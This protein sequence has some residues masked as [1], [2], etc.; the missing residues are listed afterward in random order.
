M[1]ARAQKVP[2]HP[3]CEHCATQIVG[4]LRWYCVEAEG[5][6]RREIVYS[7]LAA[8][9][10]SSSRKYAWLSPGGTFFFLGEMIV[11]SAVSEESLALQQRIAAGTGQGASVLAGKTFLEVGC[12]NGSVLF[13]ILNTFPVRRGQAVSVIS[14][15]CSTRIL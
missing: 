3:A 14:D 5:R 12:G 11:S 1:T 6:L 10:R 4:L 13:D 2:R 9:I 7:R 15:R 8:L